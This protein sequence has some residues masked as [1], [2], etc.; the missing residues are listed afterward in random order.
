MHSNNGSGKRQ[1]D[2]TAPGGGRVDITKLD[3]KKLENFGERFKREDEGRKRRDESNKSSG[4]GS[5]RF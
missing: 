4:Q 2:N 5:S 1:F 3:Q